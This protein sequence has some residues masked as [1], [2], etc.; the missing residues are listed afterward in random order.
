MKLTIQSSGQAT[1]LDTALRCIQHYYIYSVLKMLV[2]LEKN[3]DYLTKWEDIKETWILQEKVSRTPI[4]Y[5]SSVI[6]HIIHLSVCLCVFLLSIY[7]STLCLSFT[8]IIYIYHLIILY[9]SLTTLTSQ[10]L[11]FEIHCSM[12]LR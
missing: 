8:P 1:V 5:Q 4:I 2:N 6:C 10:N 11:C 3:R 7:I 12:Q 9:Y